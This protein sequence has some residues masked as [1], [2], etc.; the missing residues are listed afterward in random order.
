[1]SASWQDRVREYT[2]LTSP[3]G[4][5]FTP[6]WRGDKETLEKRV[7]QFS[8]PM[9][10]GT[11]TQDMGTE[12]ETYPLTLLFEGDD[13]DTESHRFVQALKERGPWI[14]VHPVD[15]T[16][17]LQ[18]IGTIERTIDPIESGN[19]TTVTTT[20]IVPLEAEA[21]KSSEDLG[22]S[23]ESAADDL[24]D[25]VSSAAEDATLQDT[26]GQV[27]ATI[28]AVKA[29]MATIKSALVD[30]TA[31][32][33]AIQNT[34]SELITDATVDMAQ[35]SGAVIELM[36]SPSLMS[37]SIKSQVES[38]ASLG[39]SFI[40]ALPS[41]STLSLTDRN[42]AVV[43][44][45]FLGATTSAMAIVITRE[46]PDTRAEALAIKATFS[47]FLDEVTVAL[48]DLSSRTS[49]ANLEDQYFGGKASSQALETL[50]SLV[51]RYLLSII[52]DLKVERRITLKRPRAS[53]EIAITEY[54]AT[55]DTVDYYYKLFCTSNKLHKRELIWLPAR[56]EVVV[57]V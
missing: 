3:S 36:Q 37:G 25:A 41:A 13:N 23:V 44:E 2:K 50:R 54:N 45:L 15:G 21:N 40:A 48:D 20:W 11:K 49:D 19:I 24:G 10:N 16:L 4:L 28:A 46:L 39:A 55:V 7:G 57:Y 38:L 8:Y 35:I 6:G 14:V 26:A 33:D 12:G 1:V 42:S 43:G 30:A 18:P 9:V 51:S 29:N 31:R 52:C 22:S 5:V 53:I 47:E 32:I 27:A 56:R 17:T 34:I